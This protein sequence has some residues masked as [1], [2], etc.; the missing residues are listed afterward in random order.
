MNISDII[1][2]AREELG[3]TQEDL[4][5]RLEVSRQAVSKWES[6]QSYPEMDTILRICDLY[7]VNLDTLMR[8][9][10]EDS[11]VEDTAQYDKFMNR[12]SK[13]MAF[14]IGGIIAGVGGVL[15]FLPQIALLF[16]SC[17]CWRTRAICPGRPSS[18]TGSCTASGCTA[19]RSSR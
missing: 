4:A 1:K 5:E 18:W 16:C 19:S 9:S 3:M 7:Q 6:A 11:L 8:G 17:P 13:R 2:Q 10:V 14:A 12:F 15:T